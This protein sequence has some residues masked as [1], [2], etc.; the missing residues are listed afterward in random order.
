[1]CCTGTIPCRLQLVWVGGWHRDVCGCVGVWV[2][3]GAS[4]D[5]SPLL[6]SDDAFHRQARA[7]RGTDER[8]EM[9][10][11]RMPDFVQD[12]GIPSGCRRDRRREKKRRQHRGRHLVRFKCSYTS[13]VFASVTKF[14]PPLTPTTS[15]A[16][17]APHAR[18]L[19]TQAVDSPFLRP[20]LRGF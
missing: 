16:P 17:V 5:R 9:G 2:W 6:A 19:A 13:V 15:G 8:H 12:P 11:R 7:P 3:G 20:Y 14:L 18:T 10:C 1:M 4:A